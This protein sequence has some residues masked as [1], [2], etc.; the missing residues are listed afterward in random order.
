MEDEEGK[1]SLAAPILQLSAEKMTRY[2]IF[3]M[4]YGVVGRVIT[5]CVCV[6]VCVCVRA[7]VRVRVR[8]RARVCVHVICQEPTCM[9][10][11]YTVSAGK[12]GEDFNLAVW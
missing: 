6:C 2:G 11:L 1:E 7:C 4:D 8:A 3:L 5:V 9:D 12:F 10:C